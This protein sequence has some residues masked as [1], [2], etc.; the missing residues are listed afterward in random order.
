LNR[1]AG[2]INLARLDGVSD[3]CD[4]RHPRSGRRPDMKGKELLRISLLGKLAVPRQGTKMQLPPSKKTRALLA[5]S[6]SPRVRTAAT[7]D[8]TFVHYDQR[9]HGLSDWK[10]PDFSVDAFVRDLEAVVDTLGLDRFA[11]IGSSRAGSTAFVGEV[12]RFLGDGA[13]T[14]PGAEPTATGADRGV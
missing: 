9:G 2:H 13:P 1:W 3:L 10:N 5:I 11:L 8:H 14:L 7:S 4:A 12:R 6:R